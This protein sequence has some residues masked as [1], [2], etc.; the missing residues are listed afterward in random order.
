MPVSARRWW[1]AL[2]AAAVLG[3]WP[4]VGTRTTAIS[5]GLVL[6]VGM[7]AAA[8]ASVDGAGP[9]RRV[10]VWVAALAWALAGWA[11]LSEPPSGRSVLAVA[12]G[13][14]THPTA[15]AHAGAL[16][17]LLLVVA[18]AASVLAL[19]ALARPQPLRGEIAPDALMRARAVVAAHGT[20]SLSPFVCRPDKSFHFTSGG[21]LAFRSIGGTA[22]VSGDPVGPEGAAAT[23]LGQL[24]HRARRTGARVVVYGSS[25][26]H[27]A[28]YR[29]LGL[30]A[31]CVGEE[32]VVDPARFTLEGRPVRKLRQSV[33]RIERRGWRI[34]AYEGRAIDDALEAEIDAL[35]ARWRAQRERLLGFVMSMGAFDPGVRPDDLYLLAR[36][37][38]GELCAS[39]RFLAHRG[40]LSLDTMRRV[41]D[42]PNGLNEALVC[43]ALIVARERGVPEV[44]LNYA[45]LA[46][47]ARRE[48]SGNR[49][50]RG[51]TRLALALLRRRFQMDSLV[52][53]CQ[54]F[55][56]EWR[57]RYLVYQSRAALPGA[58][59]RVLQ[60]EGYL[61]EPRRLLSLELARLR[62]LV[63]ALPPT[64]GR[65][66]R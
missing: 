32:A 48:P 6:V 35:E 22:V 29:G 59:Y 43:R 50:Q 19:R 38:S 18:V 20:D 24:L 40:N 15:R 57:P 61:P 33:H 4:I 46:H 16:G 53:F 44:S 66:S 2:L 47:L 28:D 34:D 5:V 9:L 45:G 21:V 10:T 1:V 36:S 7:L 27:L 41:G 42:S 26:R 56:P 8:G 65:A 13:A 37:P 62:R 25:E 64:L 11:A 55:S 30:R 12:R 3:A 60:A 54:K 51:L 63:A 39:M 23:L 31:I 17:E 52:Q 49:L 14:L 58:I